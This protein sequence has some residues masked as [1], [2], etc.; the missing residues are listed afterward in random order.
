MHRPPP[1]A[2]EDSPFHQGFLEPKNVPDAAAARAGEA[3]EDLHG[4]PDALP[5]GHDAAADSRRLAV[6]WQAPHVGG[7]QR[8]EMSDGEIVAELLA[9]LAHG[10][11]DR[12]VALHAGQ[13]IEDAKGVAGGA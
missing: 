1:P 8:L 10:A 11:G 7:A 6:D 12:A 13:H 9:G 3:A 2:L 4:L 5:G